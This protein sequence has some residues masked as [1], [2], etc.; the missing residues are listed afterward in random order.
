VPLGEARA[1]LGDGV[2]LQGNLDP[3]ALLGSV[4]AL[5]REACRVLQEAGDGPGYVF[6]LGHGVLPG[7]PLENVQRLVE[8]V[9]G[10]GRADPT[11][12]GS[13]KVARG[14]R[15]LERDASTLDPEGVA[16]RAP[17]RS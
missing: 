17:E 8:L 9:H 2:A 4:D 5:E 11:P 3:A 10:G 16:D 13:W 6:N 12:E 7:T 14:R 1:R 15:P